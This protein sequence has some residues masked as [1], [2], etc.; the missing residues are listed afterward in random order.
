M[1]D[2]TYE[3]DKENKRVSNISTDQQEYENA[4][5]ALQLA[6]RRYDVQG[7]DN[8]VSTGLQA[9][10][11]LVDPHKGRNPL[12]ELVWQYAS[13]RS[14]KRLPP[15]AHLKVIDILTLLLHNG[16]D[17]N[18]TDM[19]GQTVLHMACS[20]ENNPEIIRILL[21]S[22]VHVNKR[23]SQQQTALHIV[24]NRGRIR[25]MITILDGGADPNITD[26]RGFT[27]LHLAAKSKLTHLK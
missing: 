3:E 8:I 17:I 12:H 11:I 26:L 24:V 16:V 9:R 25:D 7:V 22:G 13:A 18:D 10:H 14:Q 1:Y 19:C 27:P 5:T 15:N 21:A 2:Q 4:I 20:H 6:I 23:D